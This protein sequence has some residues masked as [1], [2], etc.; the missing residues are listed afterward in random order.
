VT[1]SGAT[2]SE[3]RESMKRA[4]AAVFKATDVWNVG[5]NRIREGVE[6][7]MSAMQLKEESLAAAWEARG[8]DTLLSSK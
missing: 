6:D 7:H 4:A 5:V 2:F 1:V 8:G 3:K